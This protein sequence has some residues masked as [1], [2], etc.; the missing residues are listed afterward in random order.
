MFSI[1]VLDLCYRFLY[2][3]DVFD[4]YRLLSI[5]FGGGECGEITV[6]VCSCL[7]VTMYLCVVE[8]VCF[9]C[10][11]PSSLLVQ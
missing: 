5:L 8:S 3:V 9:R 11:V 10:D 1:C 4:L 6:Y 2:S 7:S